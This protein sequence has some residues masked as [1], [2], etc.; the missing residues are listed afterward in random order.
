VVG[1][2]SDKPGKELK[3]IPEMV[4]YVLPGRQKGASRSSFAKSAGKP[5]R[6]P[7]R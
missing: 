1:H 4:Q 7:S 3:P 2:D 6:N 5:G